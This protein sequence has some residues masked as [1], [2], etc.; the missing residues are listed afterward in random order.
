MLG[1]LNA[2]DPN[3]KPNASAATSASANAAN[4]NATPIGP[5]NPDYANLPDDCKK[6]PLSPCTIDADG[7]ILYNNGQP[8]LGPDGKPLKSSVS[9]GDCDE[10]GLPPR[11]SD[12]C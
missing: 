4:P 1:A 11:G 10:D 6:G 8:V 9:R 2:S 3:A 7:N 12:S 5:N